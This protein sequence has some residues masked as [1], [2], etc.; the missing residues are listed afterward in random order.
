MDFHVQKKGFFENALCSVSKVNR[1]P[2][3]RNGYNNKCNELQS[4]V[5]KSKKREKRKETLQI[6]RH[7]P[8]HVSECT[9]AKYATEN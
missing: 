2:M 4:N 9:H 7:A 3:E 1:Q 6:H 8:M 5:T